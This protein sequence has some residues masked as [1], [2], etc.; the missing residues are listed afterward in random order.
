MKT[1]Q[2]GEKG[3]TDTELTLT[4]LEIGHKCPEL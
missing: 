2:G 4:D 1:L 3:L